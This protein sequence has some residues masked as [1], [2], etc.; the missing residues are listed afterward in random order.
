MPFNLRLHGGRVALRDWTVDDLPSFAHWHQPGHEWRRFD[1]PYYPVPSPEKRQERV[2]MIRDR[3]EAGAWPNTRVVVPISRDGQLIGQVSRYWQSE[4]TQWLSLGI[5]VFDPSNWG[6]G[7]ACEALGMWCE[8]LFEALPELRRLDLRTWSGN[9]GMMRLATKLGFKQEACFRDARTV[10]GQ[11]YD[12]LGY[13]VLRSEWGD[14]YP[15]GFR[16]PSPAD[17]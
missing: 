10:D 2:D 11:V 16:V 14:R 6:Q 13:G 8:Y 9:I 3:I 4:E 1:G 5:V 15:G 17:D 7:L 12:G